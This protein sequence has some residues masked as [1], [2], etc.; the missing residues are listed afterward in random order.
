MFL[1]YKN[2]SEKY[3]ILRKIGEG[4]M[5]SVY[6]AISKIDSLRYAIKVMQ[7]PPNKK[8]INKKRFLE[9]IRIAKQIQS[10]YISKI[11]DS[12]FD[13]TNDE[14]WM[15]ME[16]I[17]GE[18]LKD[19]IE[20]NGGLTVDLAV[21]YS[22]Q[23][24]EGMSDIHNSHIIHRDLKTS[25]IMIDNMNRVKI[26]D[27]G[28]AIS[29]ET[30][31]H[32]STNKVIGSVHYLAPEILE[33]KAINN[34]VDIYALGILIYEMVIGK[35]PFYSDENLAPHE[36]VLKQKNSKIISVNSLNPIIPQSLANIITKATAKKPEQRYE[37]MRMVYFDLQTCLSQERALEEPIDLDRT[38]KQQSLIDFLASKKGIWFFVISSTFF[39]S[40]IALLIILSFSGVI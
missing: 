37:S 12:C 36:I 18:I 4:G 24:A 22:M 38:K 5:S 2:L 10:P 32:T 34:K 14:Y 17:E 16:Y 25:N 26:I 35:T 21:N 29:R 19:I 30:E 7:S 3:K 6:L 39:G 33:S 20:R 27:F 1:N 8:A 23:I 15:A 28:I 31:R 11:F 40:F 13:E 9:E